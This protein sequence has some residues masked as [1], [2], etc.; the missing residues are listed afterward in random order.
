MRTYCSQLLHI[1]VVSAVLA[2]AC[3]HAGIPSWVE[4]RPS[5]P[6]YYIGIGTAEK[7]GN[8]EAYLARTKHAAL[9]DIASQI[10]VLI[11]GEQ[12][13]RISEQMGKIT[14]DYQAQLRS[15]TSAELEG[16]ETVDTYETESQSWTYLRLNIEEYNRLRRAKMQQA[17]SLALDYFTKAKAS[18]NDDKA[19]DAVRSYLLALSAV[20]KYLVEPVEASYNGKKIFLVNEIVQSLQT[21]LNAIEIEPKISPLEAQIGKPVRGPVEFS[22]HYANAR[23]QQAPVSMLPVR[24]SFLRGAGELVP[25]S[26]TDQLGVAATRVAKITATDKLQMIGARIDLSPMLGSDSVLSALA[27]GFS[28]PSAKIILNVAGISVYVKTQETQFGSP[29]RLPRIEPALKGMLSS[30]GFS[31]TKQ[32]SAAAISIDITADS[33]RGSETHGLCV[34]FADATVSVIDLSTGDE[35]YKNSV[36]NM[37]GIS[38]TYE[39]AGMK[40]LDEAASVLKTEVIPLLL[41]KY[42]K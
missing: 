37:K 32:Q 25:S 13:S 9:N 4:K 11:S 39:K 30:E 26:A 38:D 2:S 28:V 15:S 5:V 12:I 17:A 10:T 41:E 29:L 21:T 31:F 22:V 14:D 34:A 40:A 3:A 8:P 36:S 23:G 20:G 18:E 24:F 42:R 33:R 16:V 6:G 7:R 1:A 19:A 27:R 35:I